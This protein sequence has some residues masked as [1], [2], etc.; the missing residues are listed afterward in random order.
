VFWRMKK[1]F[2]DHAIAYINAANPEG[3]FQM[4]PTRGSA[5]GF[6]CSER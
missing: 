4:Q 5:L 2:T 1:K 3:D 6:R